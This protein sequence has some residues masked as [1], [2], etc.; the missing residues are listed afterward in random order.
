M[1]ISGCKDIFADVPFTEIF[2]TLLHSYKKIT[3]VY[4]FRIL[5]GS[6]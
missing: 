1:D 5:D 3:E 6:P 4:D 2:P